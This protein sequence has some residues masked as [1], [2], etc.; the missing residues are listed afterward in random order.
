[1]K[2]F[3]KLSLFSLLFAALASQN[4]NYDFAGQGYSVS[5]SQAAAYTPIGQ[6]PPAWVKNLGNP[7]Y[8]YD[9][10]NDQYWNVN[11]WYGRNNS[12][13]TRTSSSMIYNGSSAAANTLWTQWKDGI[14]RPMTTSQNIRRS[15]Y[16]LWIEGG[17]GFAHNY[18]LDGRNFTTANWTLVGMTAAHTSVGADGTTNGATRLTATSGVNSAL[19]VTVE[20]SKLVTCSAWVK[21]ITGSGT[22]SISCDNVT[23]TDVSGSL[24]GSTYTQVRVPSVTVTNATMGVKFGTN[25]DAV[26]ID[27]FQSENDDQATSPVW[28]NGSIN[29]RGPEWPV[30]GTNVLPQIA[31]IEVIN[32]IDFNTPFTVYVSYSGNFSTTLSHLIFGTGGGAGSFSVTGPAGG[33]VVTGSNNG[34]T[35]TSSNSDVTGLYLGTGSCTLNKVVYGSSG[36]ESFICLNGVRTTGAK[37]IRTTASGTTHWGWGN[38]GSNVL[39]GNM[40]IPGFAVYQRAVTPDECVRLSTVTNCQ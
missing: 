5:V 1:M 40:Y 35:V 21:R 31:G 34:V 4:I 14:V 15:D 37:A 13:S 28:S 32:S 10:A 20:S 17:P 30:I 27:F 24:N 39:P 23:F 22:F 3:L 25:G 16:G 6:R 18:A 12:A 19:Q 9:F 29:L 11:V 36:S 38:N 26:D 8:A 7:K 33:G 2:K